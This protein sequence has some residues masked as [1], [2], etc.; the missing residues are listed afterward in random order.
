MN[1]PLETLSSS[2]NPVIALLAFMVAGLCGII[3]AQWRYTT[4][5][6]VPK[7]AW[8]E[9]VEKIEEV[10]D[11]LKRVDVIIEERLKK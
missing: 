10:I 1:N 5:K 2:D 6:T 4:S 11:L 7:W 3:V 8:D 9:L